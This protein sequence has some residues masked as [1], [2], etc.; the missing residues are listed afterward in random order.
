MATKQ[1]NMFTVLVNL[2]ILGFTLKLYTEYFKDMSIA[3]R[4]G[5]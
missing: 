3:K 2:I 4:K 5:V 1:T